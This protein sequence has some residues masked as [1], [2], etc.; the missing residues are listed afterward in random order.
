M[1]NVQTLEHSGATNMMVKFQE[2]H[3]KKD[4][5]VDSPA[6]GEKNMG[7]HT[8]SLIWGMTAS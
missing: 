6:C 7:I 3:F 4:W 8:M 5:H 1:G 2:N